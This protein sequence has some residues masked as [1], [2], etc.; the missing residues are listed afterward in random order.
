[1]E[2]R[3]RGHQQEQQDYVSID[4]AHVYNSSGS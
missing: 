3:L 1:V 2:R 4:C